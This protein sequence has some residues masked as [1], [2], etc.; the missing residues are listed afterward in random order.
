MPKSRVGKPT[1]NTDM[2]GPVALSS[3]RSMDTYTAYVNAGK[4]LIISFF[5]NIKIQL[6]SQ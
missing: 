4:L 1:A 2:T 5:A 6:T 3:D